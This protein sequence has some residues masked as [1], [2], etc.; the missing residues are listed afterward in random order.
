MTL[1]DHWS[2][3]T[4]PPFS[5]P[6]WRGIVGALYL[7]GYPFSPLLRRDSSYKQ[8]LTMAYQPCLCSRRLFMTETRNQFMTG[9]SV[10]R[11]DAREKCGQRPV[12]I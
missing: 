2:I 12:N 4:C 1:L 6:L 10:I 11:R 5:P 8:S 3:G 9:I 7:G